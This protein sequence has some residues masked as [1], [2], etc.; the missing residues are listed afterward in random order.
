MVD[1]EKLKS[2]TS[3]FRWHDFDPQETQYMRYSADN[4]S[5][6]A[7]GFKIEDVFRSFCN[8]RA[9]FIYANASNYG[10]IASTD[11]INRLYVKTHFLTN[12][13]IEYAICL[14]ISWQVV[15]AYIQPSSLNYLM[16]QKYLE[17]EKECNRDNL[18]A[19]LKCAI[20]QNGY[21]TMK[22]QKIKN[23][24]TEFDD[25]ETTLKLRSIYNGIKH[26]GTIH[27]NGLGENYTSMLI[28]I[29]GAQPPMLKRKSYRVEEIE[30]LLFK[31][32]FE[33]IQYMNKLILEIMPSDFTNNTISLGE[34][35][36]AL[37]R[38][39]ATKETW[40]NS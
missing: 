40:N 19:Q 3:F 4:P 37:L 10:D 9:S 25:S 34:S 24:V 1:F 29:N 39:N 16:S 2:D 18:L 32:H 7:A 27:F 11:E 15:W 6:I 13:L 33:F 31:Y 38:M 5:A 26:Q 8:A 17:M 12:A 14:D 30:E 20:S 36:E 23:L 28:S 22:A 35:I 21:G